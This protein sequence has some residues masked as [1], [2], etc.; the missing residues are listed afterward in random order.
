MSGHEQVLLAT[1]VR[2]ASVPMPNR[3]KKAHWHGALRRVVLFAQI[4]TLG[5][6]GRCGFFSKINSGGRLR[7]EEGEGGREGGR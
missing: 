3:E 4:A 7:R 5:N 2:P 1:G 6:A